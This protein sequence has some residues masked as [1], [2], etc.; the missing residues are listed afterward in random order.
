MSLLWHLLA[1]PA[2][3]APGWQKCSCWVSHVWPS[4]TWKPFKR[5]WQTSRNPHVYAFVTSLPPWMEDA[6]VFCYFWAAYDPWLRY[7]FVCKWLSCAYSLWA[8]GF[9]A[10]YV[11]KRVW[12]TSAVHLHRSRLQQKEGS[13]ESLRAIWIFNILIFSMLTFIP[14]SNKEV[15][16]LIT[17]P[18]EP[19]FWSTQLYGLKWHIAA[20]YFAHF[21]TNLID[22][23]ENKEPM[24]ILSWIRADEQPWPENEIARNFRFVKVE[25]H[26]S[27][28]LCVKSDKFWEMCASAA[29][30][31][32]HKSARIIRRRTNLSCNPTAKRPTHV[33]SARHYWCI[34]A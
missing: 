18:T 14:H 15:V 17:S 8:G 7:V 6:G 16:F 3:Q 2:A 32:Q 30:E 28:Y 5:T 26:S 13:A 27:S 31:S 20:Y 33:N 4:C 1:V 23:W 34:H 10:T 12:R 21:F 25:A 19:F 11:S 29:S 9:R 22:E 24:S